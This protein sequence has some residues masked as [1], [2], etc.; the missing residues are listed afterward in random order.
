HR[1]E[2]PGH[3]PRDHGMQPTVDVQAHVHPVHAGEEARE[4]EQEAEPERAHRRLTAP[5]DEERP[6]AER[7]DEEEIERRERERQKGPGRRREPGLCRARADRPRSI[8]RTLVHETV[9]CLSRRAA[10]KRRRPRTDASARFA[11]LEPCDLDGLN[12]PPV[13][14]QDAEAEAAEVEMLAAA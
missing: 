10:S 5:D 6:I 8:P 7:R 2:E 14:P 4:P 3:R 1:D 13:T 12:A 9:S 11:V